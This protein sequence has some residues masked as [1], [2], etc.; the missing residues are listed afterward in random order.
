MKILQTIIVLKIK[1]NNG[2]IWQH[3][4]WTNL[5]IKIVI[6]KLNIKEKITKG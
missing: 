4:K 1:I 6:S 5:I 3:K 2:V